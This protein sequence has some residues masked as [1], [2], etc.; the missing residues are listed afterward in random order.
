[1]LIISSIEHIK[2]EIARARPPGRYQLTHGIPDPNIA[3][4]WLRCFATF[5]Q[6]FVKNALGSRPAY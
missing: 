6:N 2:Y 4:I 1:M 3:D 5:S